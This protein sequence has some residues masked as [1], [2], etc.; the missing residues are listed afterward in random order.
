LGA[1]LFLPRHTSLS[2][3]V[4]LNTRDQSGRYV[5]VPEGSFIKGA[6]AVY[7]EEG[8][9]V[10]LHV[11]GF[12]IDRSEV[13]N[14][15]FAAFVAETG[16]VTEA[17]TNGG[18]AQFVQTAT[19][20]DLLTWWKLDPSATWRTPAGEGSDTKAMGAFPVVHVSLNDARAYARWAGARLPSEVEWEYAAS[21]GL[22]DPDNP[23][24]GAVA[25]DGRPLANI[26]NGLFPVIN[27][28]EDGF[29]G[30]AP[31]GCY[32]V[33]RIGTYDMIGNA[34]EWTET[35]FGDGSP[36]FTIKGGSFLCSDSYCRRFRAAARESLE[37]DFSTAHVGFRTVK[38]R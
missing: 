11:A 16:Y 17:E 22:A 5:R 1:T 4:C 29:R 13:T 32:P 24:S 27:T 20:R 28:L 18:S 25:A 7:S 23:L 10:K 36:Q 2:G 8:Q 6:G 30:L 31:V 37:P 33:S 21:L 9:P 14:D 19:P 3:P 26:W 34:W 12:L 35:P 15:Q 38:D